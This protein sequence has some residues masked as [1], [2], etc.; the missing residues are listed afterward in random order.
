MCL[1]SR[2]YVY[3]LEMILEEGKG[4]RIYFGLGLVFLF[5][6]GL[7]IKLLGKV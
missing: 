6:K 2:L 5:I 3:V 1:E 7:D 4:V